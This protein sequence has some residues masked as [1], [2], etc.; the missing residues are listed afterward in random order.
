MKPTEDEPMHSPTDNIAVTR[1]IFACFGAGDIPG[2][3]IGRASC[4]ER[5]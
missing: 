1:A 2:I 3:Q 4:R 5:V